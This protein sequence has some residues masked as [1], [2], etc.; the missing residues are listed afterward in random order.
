MPK[1]SVKRYGVE[2]NGEWRVD[3]DFAEIEGNAHEVVLYTDYAD[4][5]ARADALAE[6][7]ESVLICM[8]GQGDHSVERYDAEEALATYRQEAKP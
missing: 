8:R 6:A 4:L 3:D 2:W 1:D 5:K 7:L